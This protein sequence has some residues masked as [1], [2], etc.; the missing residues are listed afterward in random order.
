MAHLPGWKRDPRCE[1]VARVFASPDVAI[2]ER[3]LVVGEKLP[4]AA[5]FLSGRR[6]SFRVERIQHD[7]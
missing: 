4:H 6:A 2:V 5:A 3:D 7:V 1:L